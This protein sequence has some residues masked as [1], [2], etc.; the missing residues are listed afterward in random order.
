LKSVEADR[1]FRLLMG[2]PGAPQSITAAASSL[3]S[4]PSDVDDLPKAKVVK[5]RTRRR[6]RG[7]A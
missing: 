1:I 7:R 5:D 6:R 3:M 4:E 2:A